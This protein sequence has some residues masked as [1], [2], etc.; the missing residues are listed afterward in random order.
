VKPFRSPE[1]PKRLDGLEG[2]LRERSFGIAAMRMSCART[3]WL[4]RRGGEPVHAATRGAGLPSSAE[5]GGAGDEGFETPPGRQQQIDFGER[6]V[7]GGAKI[8]AF[9]F[10][11]T[12]GSR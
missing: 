8:K 1:R 11:A 5:G 10:V 12:L 3:C 4:R 2:W 9:V 7:E 6:L